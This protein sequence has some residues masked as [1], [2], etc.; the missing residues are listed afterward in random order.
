MCHLF[1]K[2]NNQ[3]ENKLHLIDWHTNIAP[4]TFHFYTI[5]LFIDQIKAFEVH[6]TLNKLNFL[7]FFAVVTGATDGIGKEYAKSVRKF[8]NVRFNE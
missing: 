1:L 4:S 2:I 6:L 5:L 3:R 8:I 7:I